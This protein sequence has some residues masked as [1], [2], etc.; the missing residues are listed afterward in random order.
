VQVIGRR[1]P[2]EAIPVLETMVVDAANNTIDVES[3]CKEF[4]KVAERI[5]NE[6]S[7]GFG[8][9]ND[10]DWT[11]VDRAERVVDECAEDLRLGRGD[12]TIWLLALESYERAW[13][14]VLSRKARRQSLAA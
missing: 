1:E 14:Q 13:F 4:G 11:E 2:Q 5:Q 6:V 12:R 10:G 3:L 7:G 9:L 8:R